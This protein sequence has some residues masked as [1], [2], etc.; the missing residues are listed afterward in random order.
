ML[1]CSASSTLASIT[2]LLLLLLSFY[3]LL[4]LCH[5]YC[6]CKTQVA[7]LLRL[8][9]FTPAYCYL[10]ARALPP[11]LPLSLCH[12]CCCLYLC[13]SHSGNVYHF[14]LPLLWQCHPGLLSLFLLLCSHMHNQRVCVCVYHILMHRRL[15][16][17]LRWRRRSVASVRG[18][19]EERGPDL[20][21]MRTC[22]DKQSARDLR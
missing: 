7:L 15:N 6:Y 4:W 19:V 1:S 2:R 21:W 17:E 18:V 8:F 5:C 10:F 14:T 3:C 20:G 12:M 9:G 11:S 16:C 13:L 22:C